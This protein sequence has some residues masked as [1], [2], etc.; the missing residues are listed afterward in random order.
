MRLRVSLP[1][2][3][4]RTEPCDDSP[5][6]KIDACGRP[7]LQSLCKRHAH[8]VIARERRRGFEDIRPSRLTLTTTI[9][10]SMRL[11][12]SGVK[13]RFRSH[14]LPEAPPPPNDP[15]PPEKLPPLSSEDPRSIRGVIATFIE[16]VARTMFSAH[17]V[18]TKAIIQIPIYS[19]DQISCHGV[20]ALIGMTWH[21]PESR[22]LVQL[23]C[24]SREDQIARYGAMCVC[25]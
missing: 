5:A 24:R 1:G 10:T 14:Q 9:T 16:A 22:E 15:P 7:V 21:D 18:R 11:C 3:A 20:Y 13:G 25:S 6:E 17:L 2:A 23:D 12:S 4:M 8:A 19:F